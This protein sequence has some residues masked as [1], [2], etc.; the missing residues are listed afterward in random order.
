MSANV[1]KLKKKKPS[2]RRKY[3]KPWVPYAF[4]APAMIVMAIMVFYP[5]LY[6]FWLSFT[7]LGLATLKNPKFI[8]LKNYQKIFTE[9]LVF[10]TFIRTIVWT[11]VNVFFHVTIGLWLA[12]LL[13]RK[14]PGKALIRV[15]LI[16]PWA[17]PQYISALTWRGM[18]NYTF[19]A[20]NIILGRIGLT[21]I[22]WL[23][24]PSMT[25]VG[26]L[27]TNIWL[28]F[29]FMMMISLGGLQ[30]IPHELYEAADIDGANGWQK[31]KNITI[32]LL[33]PVLAPATVLGSVWTFNQLNVILLIAGGYGNEKT[34]ILVTEVYRLA[35]NF[36]RYGYAA[37]Y[38][39]LI[40]FM[41]L[42]FGIVFVKQTNAIGED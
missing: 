9:G 17:V 4:L 35:F 10:A 36:Y 18:L 42:A 19:G 32:P 25:F 2:Q 7:N 23:T 26:A 13:N 21:P 38:S 24:D 3:I 30:S 40:F 12:M 31:F 11:V 29:P 39:V 37:A 41:L 6:G 28:G 15:L 33:K 8:G 1:Q 16:V 22:P 20:I 14:L 5:F 34:Q 27:L